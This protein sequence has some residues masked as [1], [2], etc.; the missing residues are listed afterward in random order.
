MPT[1][2]WT[3]GGTWLSGAR[4]DYAGYFRRLATTGFTF[5][6]LSYS[7]APGRRYPRALHQ[8]ND[9]HTYLLAHAADFNVDTDRT[10]LAGESARRCGPTPV[11]GTSPPRPPRRRWP[12]LHRVGVDFPTTWIS[13]GNTDPLTAAQS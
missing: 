3:H 2:V 7:L 5:V 4:S 9:A 11:Q 13:G 10:V 6:A 1:I 12:V 8:L